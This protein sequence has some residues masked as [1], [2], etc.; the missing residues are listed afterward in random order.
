MWLTMKPISSMWADSIRR[1]PPPPARRAIRLPRGSTSIESTTGSSSVRTTSRMRSSRPDGPGVSQ[2][3]VSSS[4]FTAGAT[5]PVGDTGASV[6]E[7][8]GHKVPGERPEQEGVEAVED[9][10]VGQEQ[11][12]RVLRPGVALEHRLEQVAEERGRADR[13]AQGERLPAVDP[14]HVEAGDPDGQRR[15]GEA[16]HR[17]LD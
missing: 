16:D 5:Y 12:A 8:D 9:A 4:R 11:A 13:E 2:S 17:P 6:D 14:V 10:S 7:P 15:R 1:G 3:V